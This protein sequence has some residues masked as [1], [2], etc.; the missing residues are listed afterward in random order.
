MGHALKDKF[1]KDAGFKK[2]YQ[3]EYATLYTK[4]LAGGTA[5]GLLDQAVRAYNRN[6]G[7]D[8]AKTTEE[9]ATLRTTLKTRTEA[10]KSVTGGA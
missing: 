2:L 3:R 10:L 6:E 8:T 4:L 5:T 7:A 1:L 9:A